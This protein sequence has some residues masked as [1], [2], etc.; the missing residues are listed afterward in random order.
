MPETRH[1]CPCCGYRTYDRPAGGTMQL[2]PVCCWEDAP[3]EYQYN[4]SNS[5]GLA[6]AQY[7]FLAM[8][9]AEPDFIDDVRAPLP[10]EARSPDWI[11]IE[12]FRLKLIEMI[13]EAFLKT[14]LEG[15]VTL[16][17]S[18][19]FD[20]LG[21]PSDAM[22]A[23]AAAKDPEERWQDIP[24][25][26]ISRFAGWS[27]SVIYLDALGFRFHLPAYMR[28]AMSTIRRE[29]LHS[30]A[31]GIMFRL[32]DGPDSSWAKDK[33]VLLN[34]PQRECV[35]AFLHFFARLPESDYHSYAVKGLQKGWDQ[36]T[37]PFVKLAAL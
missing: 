8:R 20:C 33:I 26:K 17:Q 1:P 23:E 15:G 29:N 35:A 21:Y 34:S 4:S 16:H 24:A 30:E 18:L 25:E 9:A 10:E 32:E 22:L 3:G 31:D 12:D 5:V 6:A 28:Y 13:E 27:W 14:R 36:W 19:E 7:N 2:C 11:S 37:P